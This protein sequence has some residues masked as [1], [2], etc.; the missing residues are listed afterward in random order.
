MPGTK[1]NAPLNDEEGMSSDTETVP[2]GTRQRLDH[3]DAMRPI[4]QSAVIS[5]H[6]LIYFSPL[7][8]SL[9]ASGL[10]TLTHFSRD[11]FLFV[12]ACM[13]AYSYRDSDKVKLGHYWKR[14]FMAVGL[15]YLVW[16]VIYF[17]VAA[18]KASATFPYFRVPLSSIFSAAG[19]HNLLFALFTG[20]YHLYFL[21]VLLEF[22]V[23]FPFLFKLIRRFPRSHL[24]ILIGALLWQIF[25][26]LVV[27]HGWLGFVMTSKLETRLV[28]S[29]P[30]Y[31]LGGVVAAFYLETFHD[32]VVRHQRAILAWTVV[33][34]SLPILLD[35]FYRHGYA[36]PKLIVPGG[37]PFAFAVIPYDVGAIIAVY[38][39][40][41]YLVSPKRSARTRAI[42]TSGSEAAYGIYVSQLLWI[43]LIHR[44]AVKFNILQH[45]PWLIMMLFAVTATYLL[46][47]LFSAVFARTPL[48]RGLVGR[49]QVPW[50]TLIPK[51]RSLVPAAHPDFGEGPMN[52][53]DE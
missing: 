49:S 4:K 25:Y 48:A 17:P 3:V 44:W 38:L 18:A 52:L 16:T 14:R 26:P 45:V 51:R 31:L 34:G 19:A 37:D 9:L 5:T 42:T 13:L 22:Y 36:L 24:Y 20:Y 1:G 39:L 11:A 15:V 27:R 41:V 7:S 28:F 50:N 32:W 29:Y 35:Y 21:L 53:T 10:L 23:V 30:L 40:G 33:L 43:L 6:A 47:W 46:G 2:S 12:S 8:T